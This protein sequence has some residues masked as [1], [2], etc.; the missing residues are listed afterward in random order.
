MQ[1]PLFTKKAPR[2]ESAHV[3]I[4]WVY[5]RNGEECQLTHQ[6]GGRRLVVRQSDATVRE[7]HF[8]TYDALVAFQAELDQQLRKE[9]WRL[10]HVAPDRRGGRERRAVDRG[11]PDRRTTRRSR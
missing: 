2:D 6:D 8:A 1:L 5:A 3:A 11:E 9:G 7:R 4:A 10:V